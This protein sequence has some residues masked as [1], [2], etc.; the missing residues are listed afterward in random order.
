MKIIL[1]HFIHYL[2]F[3]QESCTSGVDRETCVARPLVR[4]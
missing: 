4:E 3:V 2:H 1:E